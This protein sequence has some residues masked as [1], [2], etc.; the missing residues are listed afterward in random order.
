MSD[1]TDAEVEILL[2]DERKTLAIREE[3]DA[4]VRQVKTTLCAAWPD[5]N[6]LMVAKHFAHPDGTLEKAEAYRMPTKAEEREIL[7]HQR[8]GALRF[9]VGGPAADKDEEKPKRNWV[10]WALG[11]LGIAGGVG[12]LLWAFWPGRAE[13]YEDDDDE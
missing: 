4:P 8:N 6:T 3:A 10:P 13:P 2:A 12:G 7:K 1:V 11:G 5:G 9:L